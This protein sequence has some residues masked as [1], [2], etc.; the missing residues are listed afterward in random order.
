MTKKDEKINFFREVIEKT[1][2]VKSGYQIGLS[3]LRDYKRKINVQV[4]SKI[5]GSLDIDETTKK[6][7]PNS[8][9]W[10]CAIGYD[11]KIYFIEIHSAT[12]KEVKVV[13]AKLNWLKAWLVNKAPALDRLKADKP[14]RW[15]QSGNFQIPKDS[16]HYRI[17]AQNGILP[18]SYANL[19]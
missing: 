18:Q 12:G 8:N 11:G 17:A 13:V 5:A 7:Y 9:R 14:F 10:D 2:D 1:P 6:I 4:T 3:A 15:I 19:P 16:K